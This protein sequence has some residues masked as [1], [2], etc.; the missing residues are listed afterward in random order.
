[1]AMR[2][3]HALP[4]ALPLVA[5]TLAPACGDPTEG[6]TDGPTAGLSSTAT[7]S[8]SSSTATT[9]ADTTG[10]STSTP[11]VDTTTGTSST[12]AVDT[13][14]TD[15]ST[16][17]VDPTTTTTDPGTTTGAPPLCGN[18]VP[19]DGEECDDGNMVDDD[20]CRNNCVAPTC[21]D[22]LQ[23]QGEDKSDCGGPCT[24]C[25]ALNSECGNG[26]YC[27]AGICQATSCAG[28]LALNVDALDGD[29][30]IDPDGPGGEAPVT[31]Y[32][33]MTKGGWTC[34]FDDDFEND[35]NGW[36]NM[37]TATCA[38]ATILGRFS[39]G[40]VGATIDLLGVLHTELRLEATYYAI[41]SWDSEKAY[42]R[43]D[44]AEVWSKVCLHSDPNTCNQMSN[45]CFWDKYKDGLVSISA[46][47]PH[48]AGAA[49]IDF[50]SNLGSGVDDESFGVDDV[51]V[52]VK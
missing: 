6:I 15:A 22:G 42:A 7:G 52:C 41:D 40:P 39:K 11:G 20:F 5:L 50:G 36:S 26:N 24:P 51:R 44:G 8:S 29:Y 38:G 49:A 4:L 18:G 1:M 3:L 48:V 27:F 23:N 12:T 21:A 34:V 47:T 16:T 19:E 46:T 45:L 17:A 25:C 28:V 43:V 9:A 31:V 14:T 37:K 33:D 2:S 35:A 13:T 10:T 32:C 30:V